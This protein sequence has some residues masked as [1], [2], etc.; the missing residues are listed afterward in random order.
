MSEKVLAEKWE[1]MIHR[2]VLA[3][4]TNQT[5]AVFRALSRQ[6]AVFSISI[7]TLLSQTGS[8][9]LNSRLSGQGGF[10]RTT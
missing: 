5:F 9:N 8:K 2:T 4:Q 3:G 7:Y 6:H 1:T 10:W